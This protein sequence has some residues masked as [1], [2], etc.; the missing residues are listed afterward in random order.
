MPRGASPSNRR[1]S[2]LGEIPGDRAIVP[3]D[4]SNVMN[5]ERRSL[6]LL[7]RAPT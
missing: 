4:G 3:W 5:S 6:I 1:D 7:A 2:E